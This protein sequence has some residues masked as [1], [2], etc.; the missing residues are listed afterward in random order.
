MHVESSHRLPNP[1]LD[2][3]I[4]MLNKN[5][6]DDDNNDDDGNDDDDDQSQQW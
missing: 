6:D 2:R 4:R 1:I 3:K 5:D